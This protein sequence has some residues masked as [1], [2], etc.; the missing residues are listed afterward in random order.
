MCFSVRSLMVMGAF[1]GSTFTLE[2][3]RYFLVV[4]GPLAIIPLDALRA[5][6]LMRLCRVSLTGIFSNSL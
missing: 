1:V 4:I 2:A 3:F 6:A 5:L